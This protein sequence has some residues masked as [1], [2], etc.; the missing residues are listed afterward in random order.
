MAGKMY[1]KAGSD[2]QEKYLY[3]SYIS[4]VLFKD[5][6]LL[7]IGFNSVVG[8]SMVFEVTQDNFLYE[9]VSGKKGI[10]FTVSIFLKNNL[11]KLM[12]V[13]LIVFLICSLFSH[14]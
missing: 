3:K 4:Q 8:N 10:Q 9:N 13:L 2:A 14:S 12:C 7:G 6:T 5:K 1:S 11:T